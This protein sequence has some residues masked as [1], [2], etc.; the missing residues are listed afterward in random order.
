MYSVYASICTDGKTHNMKGSSSSSDCKLCEE[1]KY[2][3]DGDSCKSCAAGYA[4]VSNR[5]HCE[6]CQAGKYGSDGKS[7]TGCPTGKYSELS[8]Q[9]K[10][11]DCNAC[12]GKFIAVVFLYRFCYA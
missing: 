10:E 9:E 4:S 6:E 11:S 12:P 5:D 8:K 1:G 2:S 7:C 3:T